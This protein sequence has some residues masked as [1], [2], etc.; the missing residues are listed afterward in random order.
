MGIIHG[1][2]RPQIFLRGALGSFSVGFWKG[3]WGVL[4]EA[5]GCAEDID[6]T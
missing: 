4:W 3:L 5:L 2:S 6:P 1:F